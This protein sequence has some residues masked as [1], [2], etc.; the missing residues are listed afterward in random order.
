MCS[1]GI[2][3]PLFY[4]HK[5]MLTIPHLEWHVT[6]SCNFTCQGCGHFTN[7]GYRQNFSLDTLREWY[8]C[9]NK[10][11]RP[12]E[13][14]MLGG[15][16]LLNKD[17]IDIIYMT[18]DVWNPQENQTL[19]LVSNGILFDK[20]PGL[21]KAL[22]ETNCILTIT[23]HSNDPD[24]NK[25]YNKSI[26]SIIQSGVKFRIHDASNYWLKMYD[27]YGSSIEPICNDNYKESWDNCPGGQNNFTLNDFKIY[28]CAPLAYLPLQKQKYG[29]K[30][31][32]KWDPYL[33]YKPL[34]PTDSDMMI[35][36]F[37]DM[38]EEPVCSMCPNQCKLFDKISPLHSP[39]YMSK[40]YGN[41]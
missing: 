15:E 2:D 40:I 20:V 6:H 10:K 5:K 9:W 11:I 30:L 8:L 1:W 29:N 4:F 31:S 23:K 28:K 33:Q 35:I 22:K 34:L 19:E 16:P 32:H 38:K 37:F 21:P 24:Y 36:D 18:K 12:L 27:G 7:D 25:I 39:N 14:S 26:E 41:K 3:H 17:I 13:L